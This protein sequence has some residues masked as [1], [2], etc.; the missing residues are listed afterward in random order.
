MEVKANRYNYTIQRF[1][2]I[3]TASNISFDFVLIKDTVKYL[4]SVTV[5]AKKKLYKI[6]RDTT[7]FKVKNYADGT[8]KKIQDIIKKLP[9]IELNEKTG[10]IKYKGKLIETVKLDGDDLFGDTY[11]IGTKNINVDMVDAIQAIEN[12]TANPLL[13]GIENGDKIILNLTL[14]KTIL[15]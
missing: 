3:D 7:S 4:E 15:T 10:E 9:V 2:K 11:T 14:K 6:N 12:Y 13:K 5:T 8:E 1:D